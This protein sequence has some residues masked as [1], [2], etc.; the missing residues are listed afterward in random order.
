MTVTSIDK[1]LDALTM[2]IT[3]EF[4]AP[5]DAVWE[6]WANPR[7]LERW[8]GPPT[9]PATVID[10][11]LNPEGRVSYFMTGPEGDKHHGWWRVLAVDAPHRLEFEDGFADDSGTP[12][13]EMPVTRTRVTLGTDADTTRMT[14]ETSFPDR[15]AMDQMVE[16]GMVEGMSLALGQIDELLQHEATA[17]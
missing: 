17:Q 2:S 5:I 8:W 13:L 12:N 1:N 7:R 14:I 4:P 10:H 3:S 11:D 15:A 16:M 9:Y 6:M